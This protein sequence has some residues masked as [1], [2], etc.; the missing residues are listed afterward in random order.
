M[1]EVLATLDAKIM[2]Q[3]DPSHVMWER[4]HYHREANRIL[5]RTS[6]TSKKIDCLPR[7]ETVR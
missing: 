6:W 7:E 4:V 5:G 1:E 2:L 3:S